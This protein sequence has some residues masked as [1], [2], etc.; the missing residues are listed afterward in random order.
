VTPDELAWFLAFF[1]RYFECGPLDRMCERWAAGERFLRPP[2]AVTFDD[3]QRDNYRHA[4]PVLD[5]ARVRATFFVP[6][7]AASTG[8]LLWHDRAAY[9]VDAWTKKGTAHGV[10]VAESLGLSASMSPS[11]LPAAIVEKL[12]AARQAEREAWISQQIDALGGLPYPSWDGMMTFDELRRLSGEEH[13]I[14]S[15]SHSHPILTRSDDPTLRDELAISA[16]KLAEQLKQTPTSFCYPNG[17]TDE[18]VIRAT[19]ASGYRRAV[20]TAWGSNPVGADIFRLSRFDMQGST[21]RS[22]HGSLSAPRVALRMSPY[23]PR[24]G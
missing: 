11:D 2:L 18:R 22:R 19:R 12:K 13:E 6:T 8:E 3:A 21:A 1:E 17:D 23:Q 10:R 14:G 5:K 16:R 15:H 7:E 24:P 20:T 4:K 9:V